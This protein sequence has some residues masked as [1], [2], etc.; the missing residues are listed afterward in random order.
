MRQVS[1]L[2]E[3]IFVVLILPGA[4]HDNVRI[5][6]HRCRASEDLDLSAVGVTHD[7]LAPDGVGGVVFLVVKGCPLVDHL[8][9]VE[10]LYRHIDREMEPKV[11]VAASTFI[12][13]EASFKALMADTLTSVVVQIENE[14]VVT[15]YL[16]L[17]LLV[18]KSIFLLL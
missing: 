7:G 8:T 16:Y 6:P 14:R 3:V 1:V 11:I 15:G 12:H 10:E 9:I 2:E 13:V 5:I 4:A 18:L 17:H